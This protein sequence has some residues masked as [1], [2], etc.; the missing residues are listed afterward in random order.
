M[1]LVVPDIGKVE[2][3]KYMLKVTASQ[4]QILHLYSNDPTISDLTILSDLTEASGS[5]YSPINL[6]GTNWNVNQ[7]N[8]TASYPEQTF[9]FTGAISIF[10]YYVTNTNGDLLW[11]ER[12]TNAPFA[13]P[14]SG[15]Q[16]AISLNISLNDCL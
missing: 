5:G 12:F 1:A 14:S 9:A 15:G 10:G 16:I 6:T 13:L 11:C 8:T 2:L 3:L 4:N 7:A